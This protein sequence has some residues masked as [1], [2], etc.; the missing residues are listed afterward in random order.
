MNKGT[1]KADDLK[2]TAVNKKAKTPSVVSKKVQ[3]KTAEVGIAEHAKQGIKVVES[4]NNASKR[5]C[6]DTT[7]DTIPGKKAKTHSGKKI[8]MDIELSENCHE[9]KKEEIVENSVENSRNEVGECL[10]TENSSD[11]VTEGKSPKMSK[12]EN[13]IEPKN[14]AP[15]GDK[16]CS[17]ENIAVEEKLPNVNEQLNNPGIEESLNDKNC[18]EDGAVTDEELP[19]CDS[20]NKDGDRHNNN[21][22]IVLNTCGNV[23]N[24]NIP[25]VEKSHNQEHLDDSDNDDDHKSKSR[26]IKGTSKRRTERFDE[27]YRDKRKRRKH[28]SRSTSSDENSSEEE[29]SN[30]RKSERYR[31]SVRHSH[32]SKRRKEKYRKYSSRDDYDEE[33]RHRDYDEERRHRKH[34]DD[35]HRKPWKHIRDI[36][37][38]RKIDFRL[39]RSNIRDV[40]KVIYRRL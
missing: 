38:E 27:V 13:M 32:D 8:E 5:K 3:P 11:C 37:H 26:D 14:D 12:E 33:R 7:P 36:E 4:R 17:S 1:R 28:R 10:N 19:N 6:K 15:E 31:E 22:E 9:S 20:D 35:R 2:H 40:A 18:S 24:N 21:N 29:R 25:H 23:N 30:P 16:N 39:G 34:D